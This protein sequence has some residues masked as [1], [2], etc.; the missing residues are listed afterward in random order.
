[1][2]PQYTYLFLDLFTLLGPLALSFDKKVAFW[3]QWR[4][5]LPGW[6]L[7]AA[8]FI[9]WDAAFTRIGVWSFND[10][11]TLGARLAGLPV[12][13]WL[14]FL[15]V[16]YACA[17]VYACVR[18]YG[19]WEGKD[20]GWKIF[21]LLGVLLE[22]AGIAFLGRWYTATT[23]IGCGAALQVAY[24][25]RNKLVQFRAD[26]FLVAYGLCLLPFLLVNGVL[27]ALPV[28]IYND[29]ENLGVRIY[30][31]PFEDVF[32]GMLLILGSSVGLRK[33]QHPS[34]TS[35]PRP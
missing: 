13:E 10:A 20:W 17:F 2:N 34:E 35:L 31:I 25:L 24:L 11:Y 21:P 16:P 22:V 7:T 30:T 27:T 9:A 23:F 28:V 6:M 33:P 19:K 14:F 8:I 5:L 3:K 18:A 12:E 32:Y 15:A 1:M 29:A 26:A 4:A